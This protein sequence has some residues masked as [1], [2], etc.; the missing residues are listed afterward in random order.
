MK[1]DHIFYCSLNVHSIRF[2]PLGAQSE[3]FKLC[4]FDDFVEPNC[5]H[6]VVALEQFA[7]A[8]IGAKWSKINGWSLLLRNVPPVLHYF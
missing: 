1:H 7:N 6:K 5:L 4:Q 2:A 8:Q 3:H